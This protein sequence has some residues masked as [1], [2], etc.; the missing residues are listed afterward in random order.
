VVVGNTIASPT[1]NSLT[2]NDTAT[3]PQAFSAQGR[4]TVAS[5]TQNPMLLLD[6][7]GTGHGPYILPRSAR[8]TAATPTAVGLNDVLFQIAP[9]AYS[10]A[11]YA[12]GIALQ[13]TATEAWSAGHFGAEMVFNTIAAGTATVVNSLILNGNS[14]T[15]SGNVTLNGGYLWLGGG[16]GNVNGVGGP[17]I[18]GD[19]TNI[20]AKMPSPSSGGFV[21]QNQVGISVFTIGPGGQVTANSG[22]TTKAGTAGATTG[23]AFNISW[24]ASGPA[25][26]WIDNV[27]EGSIN[28]TPSDVRLKT[29]IKPASYDALAAINAIA[30]VEYDLN[31]G[32][33]TES[34][35]TRHDRIGF[36]AQQLAE[37][38]PEAVTIPDDDSMLS[39]QL[40]PIVSYLIGAVQQ[41]SAQNA[42]LSARLEALEGA[43]KTP[44]PTPPPPASTR[45][46][47]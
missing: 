32:K 9:Q 5:E 29:D 16:T 46:T 6:G 14:A 44:E 43:R 37:C 2:I 33:G 35:R 13:M 24:G 42:D 18:Y 27:D 17:L 11:A 10:G 21:V 31:W 3:Q 36:T 4:L 34:E 45:R 15:F 7:Y 47:R 8:G 19:A 28:T 39:V 12:G 40:H 26:L 41:L 30:L 23:N 22:Y 25:H 38:I 1:T 20:V